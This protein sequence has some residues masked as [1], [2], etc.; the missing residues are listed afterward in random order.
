[1]FKQERS[2]TIVLIRFD[3]VPIVFTH[4]LVVRVF[5][6]SI[7]RFSISGT[8]YSTSLLF[9]F[10]IDYVSIDHTRIYRIIYYKS[11]LRRLKD[12]LPFIFCIYF[13]I[14]TSTNH[15]QIHF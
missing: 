10:N 2:K 8:L 11:N 12:Q 1:M 6:R 3:L 4:N 7:T 9:E 5:V 14:Y 13:R 15:S